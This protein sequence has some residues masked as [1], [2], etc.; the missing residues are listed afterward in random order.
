MEIEFVKCS[1]CKGTGRIPSVTNGGKYITCPVCR[2]RGKKIVKSK[3][4]N[5]K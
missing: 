3:H 1:N 4:K 2:G 5:S